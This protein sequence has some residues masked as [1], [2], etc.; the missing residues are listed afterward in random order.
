MS[1]EYHHCTLSCPPFGAPWQGILGSYPEDRC[2]CSGMIHSTQ[3]RLQAKARQMRLM[4]MWLRPVARAMT[5]K[6]QRNHE[7]FDHLCRDSLVV[8]SFHEQGTS[9]PPYRMVSRGFRPAYHGCR[10]I[11]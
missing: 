2:V 7:F 4:A 3:V 8:T 10:R 9:H 6:E 1:G 11:V 5:N